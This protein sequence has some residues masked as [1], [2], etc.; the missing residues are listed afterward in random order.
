[1]EDLL[2]AISDLV[3]N[4]PAE[5][6]E[7]L[8]NAVYGLP[9]SAF[10]ANLHPWGITPGAKERLDRLAASWN[11]SGIPSGKLAGMLIGASHAYRQAKS[12]S[13]AELVWT[14]P[15]SELV[16]TRKTEQALLE[17][18]NRSARK[19]LPHEFRRL[20]RC[21]DHGRLGEDR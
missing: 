21:V 20:R 13:E 5:R 7:Q 9:G 15:S 17:V 1:M 12:E 4:T 19:T 14:G 10:S 18:I 8:A 11:Q 16:A 3:S 6:I 2:A